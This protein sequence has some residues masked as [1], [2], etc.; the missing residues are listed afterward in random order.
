MNMKKCSMK[1][2]EAFCEQENI[3]SVA[4][5]WQKM[6]ACKPALYAWAMDKNYKDRRD[7]AEGRMSPIV[8]KNFFHRQMDH[9]KDWYVKLAPFHYDKETGRPLLT[10]EEFLELLKEK[11]NNLYL[12]LVSRHGKGRQALARKII[13]AMPD[14]CR[15][16]EHR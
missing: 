15:V 4:E 16:M 1:E 11:E 2:I 8:K 13:E 3:I 7:T 12:W 6:K 14:K 9:V 10:Y 5:A